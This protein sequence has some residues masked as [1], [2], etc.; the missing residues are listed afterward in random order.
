MYDALK[1]FP[2][3][4]KYYGGLVRSALQSPGKKNDAS[5]AFSMTKL[6]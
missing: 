1:G 5:L 6:R 2:S 4:A 3:F